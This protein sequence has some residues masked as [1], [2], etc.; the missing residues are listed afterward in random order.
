M[1]YSLGYAAIPGHAGIYNIQIFNPLPRETL[2][3]VRMQSSSVYF[4]QDY[5]SKETVQDSKNLLK[6]KQHVLTVKDNDY[7]LSPSS[8][9]ATHSFQWPT[10]RARREGKVGK[11]ALHL[12]PL[13]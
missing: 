5:E 12:P 13:P 2:K 4:K 6:T 1:L 8:M 9:A 10:K 3:K 11:V 7:S